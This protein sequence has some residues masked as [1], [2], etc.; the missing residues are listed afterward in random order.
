[1]VAMESSS[2]CELSALHE[3]CMERWINLPALPRVPLQD[4]LI[5]ALRLGK[6]CAIYGNVRVVRKHAWREEGGGVLQ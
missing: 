1:M 5:T 6:A 3:R 4:G 2:V